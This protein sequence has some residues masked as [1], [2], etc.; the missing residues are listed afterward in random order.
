MCVMSSLTSV[1]V[2]VSTS[3]LSSVKDKLK[4]HTQ[5]RLL[6]RKKVEWCFG[7]TH[8]Y[9]VY[10]IVIRKSLKTRYKQ[11]G[12]KK[13][14]KQ[15]EKMGKSGKRKQKKV[16]K[17]KQKQKERNGQKKWKREEKMGKTHSHV[18]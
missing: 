6:P 12:K 16:G 15:K 13:G 18:S 7:H 4:N 17:E 3:Q 1:L 5:L 9:S 8:L 14:R 10:A 2:F 11:G